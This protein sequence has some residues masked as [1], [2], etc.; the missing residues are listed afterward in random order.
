MSY[1]V[2]RIIEP[3]IRFVEGCPFLDE[4]GIDMS[5]ISTNKFISSA[6]PGTSLDYIGSNVPED[7]SD[8]LGGRFVVRQANFQLWLKLKSNHDAL[9]R[10]IANFLFNFETWV[11][12][13]QHRQMT[14]KIGDTPRF[15]VMW[16]DN[17]MFFSDWD[18]AEVALYMLQLHIIYQK[19]Y[20]PYDEMEDDD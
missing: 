2:T 3:I 12:Y 15:E 8:I 16:A 10:D 5:K 13:C 9:R 7:R 20:E 1:Q 6:P 11:E 18:G 14:P 4:F 17:G 19:E